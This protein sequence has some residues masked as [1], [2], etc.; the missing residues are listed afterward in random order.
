VHCKESFQAADTYVDFPSRTLFSP[1]FGIEWVFIRTD[2][3]EGF[4]E[5]PE[6]RRYLQLNWVGP[7]YFETLGI[8]L[9]GARDFEF[10]DEGRSRVAIINERMSPGGEII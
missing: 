6:D 10:R 8:R 2:D 5:K 3:V 4:Y 7:K 1:G 9:I